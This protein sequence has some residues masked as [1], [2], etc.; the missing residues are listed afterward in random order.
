MADQKLLDLIRQGK[1]TWNAWRSGNP[2][3]APDFRGADLAGLDLTEFDLHDT[4]LRNASLRRVSLKGANLEGANLRE[5]D[6]ANADLSAVRTGLRADQLCGADLTATLLPE[7]LAKTFHDLDAVKDISESAQKLFMAMLAACLYSWLTIGTTSDLNLITNRA[8]SALPVIQTSIPIVGF[9]IIGPL[10]LLL[11]FFYFHFYLQKLWEELAS[12]PAIFPDGRPLQTKADPWLLNDLVRSHI[13]KLKGSRPFISYAQQWISILLAWWVVPITLVVFWERYLSRHDLYGTVFQSILVAAAVTGAILSYRLARRTLDGIQRQQFSWRSAI[14]TP[15]SYIASSICA[16]FLLLLVVISLGVINGTRSRTWEN[17]W[18]KTTH[19][20]RTLIPQAM[21]RLGCSP[22]ADLRGKDISVKPADWDTKPNPD[23]RS[24]AGAQLNGVDLREGDLTSAFLANAVLNHAYLADA[25]LLSADLTHAQLIDT[26]LEGAD[27]LGANLKE[28]QARGVHLSG[29]DLTLANLTGAKLE[30]ADLSGARLTGADLSQADL[31][32]ANLQ[33]VIV[34]P[35]QLKQAQHLE[36][37]YMNEDLRN[38]LALPGDRAD[39]NAVVADLEN[40]KR[41]G[42]QADFE[43]DELARLDSLS[44]LPGGEAIAEGLRGGIDKFRNPVITLLPSEAKSSRSYSVAELMRLYNFPDLDGQGQTIGII[45]LGGGFKKTD[46]A[47]YFKKMNIPE[48]D[49][50]W[51]SVDNGQNSPS[52]ANSADGEVQI[53]IEVVGS[54]APKAKIVVYFTVNTDQGYIDAVKAAIDDTQNHPKVIM[55]GWGSAEGNWTRDAMQS[56]DKELHRAADAGIT[57]IAG[58]GDNGSTDGVSDGKPHVDFPGSSQW[59]LTVGGTRLE[60]EGAN[61]R[62]EVVWNDEANNEGAGGTGFSTVFPLP[63]W[64]EGVSQ[65][66]R[67]S[68]KSGRSIPDV[69]INA[70]PVTGYQALIDGKAM[71]LGGTSAA[72]PLWA[73]L[74]ALINQGLGKN[75][76]YFNPILYKTIGSTGAFNPVPRGEGIQPHPGW[77]PLTGWGTPDG[78]KLLAA[79]RKLNN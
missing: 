68:G 22:F 33:N 20:S 48:P 13:S 29:A 66:T 4:N 44:G 69:S 11:T 55:T 7:N 8:T 59:A 52:N 57:F 54:V 17:T 18:W 23:Y 49:V 5:A 46:L 51:K 38:S 39:H 53:N 21:R 61:I 14:A 40:K 16:A 71:V 50:T 43:S 25:N 42:K 32:Y 79:L 6:V 72:A 76:G 64:Q 15:A 73:G 77:T 36:L 70:S 10:L 28:V 60:T 34:D 75:V 1:D 35:N 19:G 56:I 31:T 2:E 12:L 45:E 27:L 74:I 62:S 67:G 26:H 47:S 24:I 41:T 37:A 9:Y 78:R 65:P 63:D 30:S 58:S 3:I